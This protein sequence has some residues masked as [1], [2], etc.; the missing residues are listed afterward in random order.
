MKNKYSCMTKISKILSFLSM[1]IYQLIQKCKFEHFIVK[2]IKNN[3]KNYYKKNYTILD[4]KNISLKTLP[5]L[6]RT[7]NYLTK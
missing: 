3:N 4:K 2:L 6:Y 1:L 5:N 7:I